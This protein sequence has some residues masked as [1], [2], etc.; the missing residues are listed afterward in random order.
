M[1]FNKFDSRQAAETP[2][3]LQLV[4]P[5]TGAL[6]FAD[7]DRTKPCIVLVLGAESRSAQ[8]AL[9]AIRQAKLKAK[10][11]TKTDDA[12]GLEDVHASIVEG[13]VPLIMGF[14]NISRGDKAA[15]RDDA[16]WFLNLQ[17]LNG[18]EGERSFVEQVADFATSRANF[19]GNVSAA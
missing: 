7:E 6:L 3:R 16:E 10:A 15:T 19:L 11:K 8:A 1:D 13:T 17:M 14:E 12:D 2:A 18:R 4:D 9:R 5:A